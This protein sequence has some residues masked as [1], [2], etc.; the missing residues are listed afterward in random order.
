MPVGVQLQVPDQYVMAHFNRV[1]LA[2]PNRPPVMAEIDLSS[3]HGPWAP[4]P[5]MIGWD[6]IGDGS[7][8]DAM[9]AQGETPDAL[10]KDVDKVRAAYATSIEYSLTTLI[11][12]VETYGD[13]NLV[14]VLVGDHQPATVVSGENA[15]RDVPITL[16]TH[17]KAVMNRTT[18]GGGS[19]HAAEPGGTGVADRCLPRPFPTAFGPQ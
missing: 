17:D 1:E 13:P 7:V 12:F 19:G 16:I 3:S 11:S 5:H 4:L 18:A 6:E 15:S 8:Y 14:I 10:F 9:A 2:K